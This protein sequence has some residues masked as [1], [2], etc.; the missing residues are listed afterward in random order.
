MSVVAIFNLAALLVTLAAVFGYLNHRWLRLPHTIGL[1][2][3]S[4]VVSVAILLTDAALPTLG[5]EATV[6]T[7]LTDIELWLPFASL[8]ASRSTSWTT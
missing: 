7:M 2:V 6:R 8:A 4:L 1:V 3:I 5:L